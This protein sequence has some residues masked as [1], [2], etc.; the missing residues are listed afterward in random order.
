MSE[1][2]AIKADPEAAITALV[3]RFTQFYLGRSPRL[4]VNILA[5]TV[6]VRLFDALTDGDHGNPVFE[7]DN[8][9]KRSIALDIAR[10]GAR[11]VVHRLVKDADVFLTNVRPS[12]LKRAGLDF[13]TLSALNPRLVYASVTGYGLKGPEADR[14][15]F[16]VTAFWSRSG[17]AALTAPKGTDPFTLRTGQGDHTT[18]LATV[19]A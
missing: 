3:T 7:L 15:G 18:T 17:V 2:T 12:A 11:A 1:P 10:P 19:S 8:R 16:D 14:P 6:V 4:Q 13:E 9:G 5:D